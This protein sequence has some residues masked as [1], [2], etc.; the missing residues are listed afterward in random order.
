MKMSRAMAVLLIGSTC[1][2]GLGACR[3]A[4]T[5]FYSV[6]AA[7][8]GSVTDYQ[9]PAVRIDVVHVPVDI[10]RIE[11][12]TTPAPGQIR[13]NEMDHWSGPLALVARQALTADLM[14]R[15]PPGKVVFPHLP[16]ADGALGI[17]VDVLEF[18]AAAGGSRL[19][20]SWQVVAGGE[21]PAEPKSPVTLSRKG[22][23]STPAAVSA[24][25][26]VLLGQ[27][28]DRIAADLPVDVK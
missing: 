19:V 22:D 24:E 28:A 9:G 10:D 3:S 21:H 13:I 25:L 26:S 6:A 17:R 5:R 8:A 15:L 11:I 18:V 1:A 4:A 20:A 27:L 14:A 23:G 12:V 7:P 2:W 16:K